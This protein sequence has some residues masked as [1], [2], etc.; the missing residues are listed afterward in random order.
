[1][2]GSGWMNEWVGVKPDVRDCFAHS[3]NFKNKK[4]EIGPLCTINK[5]KN[6]HI[7]DAFT[8]LNKMLNKCLKK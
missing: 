2:V 7:I 5:I 3:K 4:L 8:K 6:K 1:L